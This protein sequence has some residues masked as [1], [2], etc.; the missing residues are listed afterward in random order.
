MSVEQVRQHGDAHNQRKLLPDTVLWPVR[1]RKESVPP[2]NEQFFIDNRS[3]LHDRC[4]PGFRCGLTLGG[5]ISY[6]GPGKSWT[7]NQVA[8]FEVVLAHGNIVEATETED[9]DLGRALR[10]GSNNFGVI[11]R[12]NLRT[13]EQ[14]LLWYTMTINPRLAVDQQIAIFADLMSPQ[15]TQPNDNATP[16]YFQPVLDLPAVPVPGLAGTVVANMSRLA[17]NA[18]T[19][20]APQA[21]QY[22]TATVT[23]EPTDAMIK[24]AYAAFSKSLPQIDPEQPLPP[25]IYEEQGRSGANARGLTGQG[26]RSLVVYLISPSWSDAAQIQQVY[27]AAR[28]LMDDISARVNAL[29]IHDPYIYLNYAAPWQEV[30]S[31]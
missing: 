14:G 31:S 13:F 30:L 27:N 12:I 4:C 22:M 26:G 8:A 23:F 19:M 15:N 5:G 11:T 25:Q 7:C 1:P 9:A 21:A 2:R 28:V 17:A 18:A 20:Q 24:E 29:G 16:P 6:C 3:R 10:G